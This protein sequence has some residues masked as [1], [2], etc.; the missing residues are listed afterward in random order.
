MTRLLLTLTLVAISILGFSQLQTLPISED[1]SNMQLPT[2]WQ[3]LGTWNYDNQNETFPTQN[4]GY[5]VKEIDYPVFGMGSDSVELYTP[6]YDV[7]AVTNTLNLSMYYSYESMFTTFCNLLIT[8]DGGVSWDTI[9]HIQPA[10]GTS[11]NADLS[12]FI[13]GAD[14]IQIRFSFGYQNAGSGSGSST[15]RFAF[16]DLLVQELVAKDLGVQALILLILQYLIMVQIL[17]MSN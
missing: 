16:D 17:L 14:S 2:N 7:T 10:N 9:Q 11:F 12:S 6:F 1:F 8:T 4:N 15:A 5:I 13:V 3:E